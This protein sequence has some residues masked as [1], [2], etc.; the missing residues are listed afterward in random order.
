M[1]DDRPRSAG[2]GAVRAAVGVGAVGRRPA[3]PPAAGSRAGRSADPGAVAAPHPGAT[4]VRRGPRRARLVVKRIDP[5]SVLKLTFVYSLAIYVL[6]LVAATALYGL[7]AGMGVFHALTTFFHTIGASSTF[8]SYLHFGRV[9]LVVLV[10]GAVNVVL[11][12]ALATLGAFLYNLCGDL[13]GGVE[14]TL[15]DTD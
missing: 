14:L 6:M 7:L 11:L 3:E 8:I 13:V 5:W 2:P 4:P 1:T 12:T 15:T 10:I 9:F